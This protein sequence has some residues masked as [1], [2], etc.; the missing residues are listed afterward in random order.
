MIGTDL[1]DGNI[2]KRGGVL[3]PCRFLIE[4]IKTKINS[5]P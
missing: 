2:R 5:S 3:K 4:T 1:E